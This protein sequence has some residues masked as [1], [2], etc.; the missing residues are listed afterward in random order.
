MCKC[1]EVNTLSMLF[2]MKIVVRILFGFFVSNTQKHVLRL[3]IAACACL[4]MHK[5][6]LTRKNMFCNKMHKSQNI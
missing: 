3:I 2:L 1:Y 5:Q 6:V 4:N